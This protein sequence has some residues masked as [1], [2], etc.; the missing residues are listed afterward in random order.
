MSGART[1]ALLAAVVALGAAGVWWTHRDPAPPP[2]PAP[3]ATHADY[4]AARGQLDALPVRRFDPR[5]DYARHRFGDRWSDEVDVEGGHNGCNTRDDILRRDLVDVQLRWGTCKVQSG[6][7]HD[8]YTGATIAFTRGPETSEAVQ[9]DHLVALSDAWYKGA[10][11]WDRQRRA[12]FANDPRNLLAVS[13]PANFDKAYHD[14]SGWLPPNTAFRCEFVTRQIAVKTAYRLAVSA[15][16]K[17]ALHAVLTT[18]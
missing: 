5:H 14:A 18:C 1:A 15:R 10:R 2:A 9:I 8:P 17:A 13:G 16:E 11:D 7:L 3:P 6:I 4:D 12:D